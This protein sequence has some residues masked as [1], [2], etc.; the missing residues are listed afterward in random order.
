MYLGI[1][2]GTQS[3]KTLLY[4]AQDRVVVDVQSAPLDLNSE[5]DGTR[6]QMAHWWL[7]GLHHCI[8]HIDA[9]KR[10]G[11]Q[12][13]AVSGQQHGLVALD[14]TDAV[15]APVKLWCDTSTATECDEITA[16]FG[17]VQ[18]LRGEVGNEM[19]T[20]YTAPKIRWM[21]KHRPR[22]YA[23]LHTVLLPHDYINFYLTGERAMEMGDASGT[24]LLDVRNRQWHAELLQ[25]LDEDRDLASC[26]PPL[27]EAHAQLGVLRA[28]PAQQLGLPEGTPVAVGGG[29]NMMA[30]IG[31]G[32]VTAGRLTVSLGTSGTLFA[33]SDS[34]VVDPR[35]EIAAFCSSTGAWLPLLCTMNCTAATELTR[36]IF[37]STIDRQEV[38]I[39]KAPP[40]SEG[41]LTVP[42]FN[43]ERTPNLPGAKASIVGL[44]ATN[45]TRGNVM[46]SAM[47][48]ATY[49]LRNGLD[50]FS[51]LG[52]DLTEVCLT[53][54]G[55]GSASWRQ[56]V[57]DV[58]N[59][60]VTILENG[61]GAAMGA[62]LQAMWMHQ[63]GDIADI[64]AE[65]LHA[66]NEQSAQ[67]EASAVA[68]YEEGY[69]RYQQYVEQLVP[70][71]S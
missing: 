33:H 59:R 47:E 13:I 52:C 23:Q 56:M 58:F 34:P 29:D 30:A 67:P 22:R 20:G 40:G 27:L 65:H 38:L 17:G 10:E 53:G 54:G 4:D 44:D 9:K 7:T 42:F 1:D 28:E 6:E 32:N 25:I 62:A 39:G 12:A 45:Y 37:N 49:A 61:E 66:N 5:A 11:I 26:M 63:G 41:I 46:R 21:K 51:R 31:T 3:V 60:P 57:A 55:A 18:R 48:G 14:D 2:I 8:T 71:Y 19:L 24:G 15:V 69:A 16:R 50:A 35:G 70:I 68:Q 64:T 36:K 43:G